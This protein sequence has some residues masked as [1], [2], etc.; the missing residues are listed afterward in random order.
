M[1][2]VGGSR[3]LEFPRTVR[4]DEGDQ[5]FL[6][7]GQIAAIDDLPHDVEFFFFPHVVEFAG[8]D[9]DMNVVLVAIGHIDRFAGKFGFEQFFDFLF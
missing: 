5:R 6:R 2:G 8:D 4:D 7:V 9:D 3:L 1:R